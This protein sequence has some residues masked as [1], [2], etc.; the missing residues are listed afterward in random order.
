MKIDVCKI[1]AMTG[2]G[3][4]LI[5]LVLSLVSAFVSLEKE[6]A[7]EKP[8][9]VIVEQHLLVVEDWD[10]DVTDKPGVVSRLDTPAIG[11]A[12][13]DYLAGSHFLALETG[14]EILVLFET[15]W[16]RFV[17]EDIATFIATEPTNPAGDLID[18][19]GNKWSA[20]RVRS[21]VYGNP[22]HLVL[23]TC[24]DGI[25]QR[26]FVIAKEVQ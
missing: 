4:F 2:Q 21:L 6:M 3:A 22:D 8:V 7:E 11:F 18:E 10:G 5:F 24:M 17:V 9:A 1:S 19:A 13:H 23:Q 15:T 20:Y 14:N 16:S 25:N 12:A 26:L